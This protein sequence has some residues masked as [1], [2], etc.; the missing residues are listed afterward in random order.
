MGLKENL[1]IF[2]LVAVIIFPFFFN[3]K[4]IRIEKEIT[5]P[6]IVIENGSF[7]KFIPILQ[8]EGNFKRLDYFS[9][10]N[11]LAQDIHLNF[12]DKNSSFSA[13][14]L[15]YDGI[16]KFQK[17]KYITDKYTYLAQHGIYTDKNDSLIAYNF[18]LFNEKI[19]AKGH[20]MVYQNKI[21]KADDI[22]YIIKGL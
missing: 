11:F 8:R 21:L 16:Y 3:K 22:K 7:K 2:F 19:D 10:K 15:L 20:K 14:E 9:Q 13:K 18:K 6:Y 1:F 5:L 4:E 12:L 17:A